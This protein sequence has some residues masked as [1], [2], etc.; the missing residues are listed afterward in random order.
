MSTINI[1][2]LHDQP[3]Y[4][5]KSRC[6]RIT[7]FLNHQIKHLSCLFEVLILAM[8][9]YKKV[10]CNGISRALKLLH[11]IKHL[12]DLFGSPSLDM[13]SHQVIESNRVWL[14]P[15]IDHL[16]ENIM[17]T[18]NLPT[19][20]QA[21]NHYCIS[22]H[23]RLNPCSLHLSKNPLSLRNVT[24]TTPTVNQ[25]CVQN[26]IRLKPILQAIKK[27]LCFTCSSFLAQITD[28]NR[29][30]NLIRL[31]T[32]ILHTIKSMHRLCRESGPN[33]PP[34]KDC[35]CFNR[36]FNIPGFHQI[37]YVP[38]QVKLP[39]FPSKVNHLVIRFQ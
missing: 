3:K 7:P 15:N 9:F 17:G 19:S 8:T 26:D 24:R 29:E 33:I 21:I 6:I 28:H 38:S 36:D 23:I 4:R 10:I 20:T 22:I 39:H 31:A 11:L 27:G 37:N 25:V 2:K 34:H 12:Q 13:N 16:R 1:F 5:T 35:K 14:A 32:I 18:S 30:S